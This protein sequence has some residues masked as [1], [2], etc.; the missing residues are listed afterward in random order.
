MKSFKLIAAALAV[1]TLGVFAFADTA[2]ENYISKFTTLVTNAE[3]CAKSKDGSK[4]ATIKAQ[5]VEIDA[6]RKTVTLST[7]QRF[8]DWRLTKRY[9]S[10]YTKIQAAAKTSTA[11]A[12]TKTKASK[13]GS[14]LEDAA[15]NVGGALKE[16]GSTAVNSVKDSVSNAATSAKD[17]AKTKVD[18]SVTNATN[19]AT[20]KIQQ[21]AEG[22]TNALNNLL[23]K[24]K[25]E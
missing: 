23:K 5:K 10:A 15:N 17:N 14:A 24:D 2:A 22:I 8:T 18:E 11:T 9:E 19:A 16:T 6:L 7:T 4:A 1:L 13:V 21:G 25:N 3:S 20:E 12:E